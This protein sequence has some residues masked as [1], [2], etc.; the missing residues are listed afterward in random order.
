MKS[1]WRNLPSAPLKEEKNTAALQGY[2]KKGKEIINLKWDKTS[3]DKEKRFEMSVKKSVFPVG[4]PQLDGTVPPQTTL[5]F[6][7][8][9][10]E[11]NLSP[12]S[13]TPHLFQQADAISA[14]Y[15]FDLHRQTAATG[16][17]RFWQ[18]TGSVCLYDSCAGQLAAR[19]QTRLH[20]NLIFN[21]PTCGCAFSVALLRLPR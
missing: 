18:L 10:S 5:S 9:L 15:G 11:A 19:R 16:G 3:S 7:T 6:V 1:D 8:L 17:R 14:S 2:S 4:H 13:C 21:V 12:P 20:L